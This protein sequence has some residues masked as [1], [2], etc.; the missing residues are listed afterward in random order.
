M[1]TYK[2]LKDLYNAR[3]GRVLY[4]GELIDFD[5]EQAAI[6]MDKHLVAPFGPEE[7]QAYYRKPRKVD[8]ELEKLDRTL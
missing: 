8:L 7:A 2:V 6:L 1:K 5:D 4:P 3:R